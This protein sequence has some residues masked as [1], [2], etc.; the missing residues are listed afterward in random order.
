MTSVPAQASSSLSE[1]DYRKLPGIRLIEWL[2]N[3]EGLLAAS[4]DMTLRWMQN[5]ETVKAWHLDSGEAKNSALERFRYI[6]VS[7]E[8]DLLYVCAGTKVFCLSRETGEI[9]WW[10]R[11]RDYM[12]FI[13]A[14]P[15]AAVPLPQGG[16]AISSD[17]G[18]IDLRTEQGNLLRR[19]RDE[20][21]PQWAYLAAEQDLIVGADGVSLSTWD[22]NTLN[23]TNHWGFP[24]HVY[25]MAV[26]KHEDIAVVRTD[27]KV[28]LRSWKNGDYVSEF[29]VDPGLA[30]VSCAPVDSLIAIGRGKGCGIYTWDGRLLEFIERPEKRVLS[31]NFKHD[32]EQSVLAVGYDDGTLE[33]AML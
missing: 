5:G 16:V 33:L 20:N 7:A 27:N 2:P 25:G 13:S 24:G 9:E 10:H 21:A 23:R 18:V 1:L 14:S 32:G 31:A 22:T 19:K 8:G 30:F 4:L 12:G 17:T 26:S 3:N 11:P 28:S 15:Y 29:P 6:G